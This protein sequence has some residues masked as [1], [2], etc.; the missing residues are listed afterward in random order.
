MRTILVVFLVLL[1]GCAV[2]NKE[3]D[4]KK[5]SSDS[6]SHY[7]NTRS[8]RNNDSLVSDLRNI[9]TLN[10]NRPKIAPGESIRQYYADNAQTVETDDKKTE[11]KHDTHTDAEKGFISVKKKSEVDTTK[12]VVNSL[13][14]TNLNTSWFV[15]LI[16]GAIVLIVILVLIWKFK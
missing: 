3:S 13:L 10:P 6:T 15:Y 7:V 4:V 5:L 9:I 1:A 11:V 8:D 2:K 16:I 12:K 14:K